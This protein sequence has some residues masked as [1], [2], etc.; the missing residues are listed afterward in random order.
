[1]RS[2]MKLSIIIP[3]YNEKSTIT[4]LLDKLLSIPFPYETEIIVVDD[5]STDG[6]SRLIAEYGRDNIIKKHTSLINL[7]KGAAVRFGLEYAEGDFVI[8]QDADLELDPEDI[9]KIVEAMRQTGAD[10]V[11]GSRFAGGRFRFKNASLANS[12]AN[13][14]MTGYTNLLYGGSLT[15]MSTAYKL[16]RADALKKIRLRSIGF[17]FEPEI[18]AKLLRL[19]YK[20]REVPIAYQPRTTDQGKKIAWWDGFKYMYYLTKYRIIEKDRLLKK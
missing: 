20:I 1:M 6:T 13:K 15:D 2:G 18:T 4:H 10:A 14:I 19:G 17:E 5:G 11:Y 7:G 3:V 9:L 12:L 8:I 16:I